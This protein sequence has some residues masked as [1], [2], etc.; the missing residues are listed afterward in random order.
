[1]VGGWQARGT[2]V[3]LDLKA[4]SHSTMKSLLLTLLLG[5]LDQ[6]NNIDLSIYLFIYKKVKVS[7]TKLNHKNPKSIS[8]TFCDTSW[9]DRNKY[10][11]TE[12][13]E[14]ITEQ[15]NETRKVQCDE[16][17]NLS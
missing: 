16:P 1:M 8:H 11:S 17:V 2:T 9:G 14:L 15:N 7:L 6:F 12:G 10:S 4:N 3:V 13:K 5:T